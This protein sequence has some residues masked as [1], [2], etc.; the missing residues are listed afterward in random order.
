MQEYIITDGV[1][2]L[3]K[4]ITFKDG[5]EGYNFTGDRKEA[6]RFTDMMQAANTCFK[7]AKKGMAMYAE[8]A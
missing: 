6:L 4:V 2:Y 7:M 3:S 1:D 8:E 5:M